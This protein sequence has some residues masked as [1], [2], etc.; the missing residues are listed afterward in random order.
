MVSREWNSCSSSFFPHRR[1]NKERNISGA[2]N[3][4]F[5]ATAFFIFMKRGS[6]LSTYH[7]VFFF[8]ISSRD[9]GHQKHSIHLFLLWP[10]GQILEPTV[11]S[12]DKNAFD[13]GQTTPP[14]PLSSIGACCSMCTNS[15]LSPS[16]EPRTCLAGCCT[17]TAISPPSQPQPSVW[18]GARGSASDSD[19]VFVLGSALRQARPAQLH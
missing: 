5:D 11:A 9:V 16:E 6:V 10:L 1:V 3:R 12:P 15:P 17:Q 18:C 2:S 19:R 8:L 4:Y 7:L 13:R 14:P